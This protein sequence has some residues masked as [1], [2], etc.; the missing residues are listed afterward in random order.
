MNMMD[1]I[2]EQPDVFA[3]ALANRASLAAPF[4]ELFRAVEPDRLCP[5]C[6]AWMSRSAHRPACMRCTVS[7]R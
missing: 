5:R 1:Y 2:R 7:A 6:W 4:V 3:R